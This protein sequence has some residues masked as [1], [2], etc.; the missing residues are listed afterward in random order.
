MK[1]ESEQK[2]W[3]GFYAQ[4]H[5]ELEAPSSF[6]RWCSERLRAGQTLFELGCGNGRDALFFAHWGL[7]VTAC[8]RSEVAIAT[9][10]ARED[11]ARFAHRPSFVVADMGALDDARSGA[12]DAVYTRFT[13]HAVSAA[14][15]SRALAWG[16][17]NLRAGGQLLIEVRSVLGSLFG[18]GEQVERDA[19]IHDGHYR[20]FVR[21]EELEREV[22]AL[23]LQID[24]SIESA[25][26]AVFKDD[27]PV[28]I[29]LA[30]TKR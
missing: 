17:R 25:G 19:F 21:R 26:L 4:K 22:Q 1:T 6:A 23:G 16:Q 12:L 13:L 24:A 2:Y 8:D 27:D 29:R 7:M 20:R 18:K 3:D 5:P 10:N 9:L 11:L 30:A 28:V 14:Q 15:A